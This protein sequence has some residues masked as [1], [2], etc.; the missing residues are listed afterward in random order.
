MSKF[1]VEAHIFSN[2]DFPSEPLHK[3]ILFSPQR[4]AS[5]AP[6]SGPGS[7]VVVIVRT[8]PGCIF[9]RFRIFCPKI[10]QNITLEKAR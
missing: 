10:T 1:L 5:P 2:Y 3:K 8:S 4:D 6:A 7:S 9:D